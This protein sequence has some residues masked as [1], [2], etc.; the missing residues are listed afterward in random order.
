MLLDTECVSHLHLREVWTQIIVVYRKCKPV[1]YTHL[2]VYK[3]Q[4]IYWVAKIF[5]ERLWVPLQKRLEP[6]LYTMHSVIS[7]FKLFHFARIPPTLESRI[8]N[9]E[10]F[11]QV[12]H[13]SSSFSNLL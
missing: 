12:P 6:L 10:H 2:D 13:V 1:S 8:W 11:T 4:Y 5:P 3:R 9:L 7:Q